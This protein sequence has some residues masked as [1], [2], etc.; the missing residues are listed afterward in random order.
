MGCK[1]EKKKKLRPFQI[2]KHR[3]GPGITLCV[4]WSTDFTK[5]TITRVW[6]NFVR[7]SKCK[8]FPVKARVEGVRLYSLES[9]KQEGTSTQAWAMRNDVEKRSR[10]SLF[11]TLHNEGIFIKL[12]DG[13]CT[14]E[15]RRYF[16]TAK[17]P[18]DGCAGSLGG[19]C[20]DTLSYVVPAG[21]GSLVAHI[22]T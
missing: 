19:Y 21:A 9:R 22:T 3:A 5:G 20:P 15:K 18:G 4:H 11:P 1:L 10:A 13:K 17:I 12:K 7:Q 16:F 2:T 6:R 14:H 8:T